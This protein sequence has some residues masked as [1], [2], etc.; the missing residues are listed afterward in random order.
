[1]S[2]ELLNSEELEK[3]SG[4]AGSH[5]DIYNLGHFV[6]RTVHVPAGTL[7]VMQDGPGGAFLPTAYQDGDS[8]YVNATYSRAGYLL[9]YKDGEYGYVDAHYVR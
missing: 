3:V 9:A 8:I 6:S 1:M 4:G 2:K 7:L 5:Q